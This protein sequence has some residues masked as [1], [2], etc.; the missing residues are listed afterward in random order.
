[1]VNERY[2]ILRKIGQGSF[3]SVYMAKDLTAAGSPTLAL[4][5]EKKSAKRPMLQYEHKVYRALQ[6]SDRFCRVHAFE[7]SGPQHLLSM[8]LLGDSIDARFG[9]CGRCVKDTTAMWLMKQML[10]C[11]EAMHAAFFL[12]RDIKPHNFAMSTR[13]PYVK[14]IDMGL[15]KQYRTR[16]LEH[17]EC[18]TD[19]KLTGTVRYTSV[20]VHRG[21][22]PSRRDDLESLLYVLMYLLR[23]RLPW[24]G[25]D[26]ECK[27]A[28]YVRIGEIKIST[29][30]EKLCHGMPH[31]VFVLLKYVKGIMFASKPDYQYMQ[32]VIQDYLDR[33][34]LRDGIPTEWFA[35]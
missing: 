33:E 22:E 8:E 34:N 24:Q 6:G 21:I 23:G 14:L 18:K 19:R 20:N 26:A 15:A 1:M 3:G 11:V 9:K 29:P 27:E 30:P 28:K 25:V 2:E 10:A 17:I 31:D 4:K 5:L 7:T 12:H 13:P 16:N 32:G 35:V